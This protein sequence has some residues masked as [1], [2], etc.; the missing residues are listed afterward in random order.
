MTGSLLAADLGASSGRVI[1]AHVGPGQLELNE[2]RR[3][4][5][6]PISLP[7]GLYWDILGLYQDVLTGIGDAARAHDDI[8]GIAIDSWAVDY[9]LL[10]ADGSLIG[11]P[12]H[13]RDERSAAGVEAIHAKIEPE[14]ALRSQRAT[15]PAV[16][17]LI[18]AR[19]R[20]LAGRAGSP[21]AAR[22]RSARVLAHWARGG[23]ADECLDHRPARC[24]HRRLVGAARHP[25]RIRLVAV[26]A[27]HRPGLGGRPAAPVRAG[28][29]RPTA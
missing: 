16:Q 15:A 11:N 29:Y 1:L 22:P 8:V 3:F 12:R 17:Y 24:P 10:A 19:G 2:I 13:Y 23:R 9:G 26:A 14:R 7:D 25:G 6:G 20:H 4:R 18:S 5:N 21:A 28:R 27:G